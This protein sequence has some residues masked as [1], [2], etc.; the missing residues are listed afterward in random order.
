MRYVPMKFCHRDKAGPGQQPSQQNSN[1]NRKFQGQQEG[2]R[3]KER[4]VNDHHF[5]EARQAKN[6][7]PWNA[8]MLPENGVPTSSCFRVSGA[9]ARLDIVPRGFFFWPAGAVSCAVSRGFARES[10]QHGY[11]PATLVCCE[12]YTIVI[13]SHKHGKRERDV[14]QG[15]RC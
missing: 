9:R 4:S 8:T 14:I 1:P 12:W 7:G 3:G 6:Q 5:T 11:V 2:G 13:I 15:L 10:V